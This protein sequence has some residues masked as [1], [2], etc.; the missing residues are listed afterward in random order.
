M[1]F[2]DFLKEHDPESLKNLHINDHYRVTRAYEHYQVM[3]TKLSK[4]KEILDKN[5]PYNFSINIHP[6]FD[7]EHISLLVEKEKHW[8][9]MKNRAYKMVTGGLIEEV[10]NILKQFSG[11][12]KPLASIGYKETIDFIQGKI[13]TKEELSELIYINTRKLAKAQKTFLKKVSPKLV[14]DPLSQ[15]DMLYKKVEEFINRTK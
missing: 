14:I 3:G 6:N 10:D 1:F 4:Q 2:W 5:E 9:I 7:F 11:D 8:E 15:K 12:E 13:S